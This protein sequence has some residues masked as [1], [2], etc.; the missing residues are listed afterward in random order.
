[1]NNP[2]EQVSAILSEYLVRATDMALNQ[3]LTRIRAQRG[4]FAAHLNRGLRGFAHDVAFVAALGHEGSDPSTGLSFGEYT[5]L[6]EKYRQE[7][8]KLGI[9]NGGMNRF[10]HFS[11][12]LGRDLAT[13]DVTEPG[14]WGKVLVKDIQVTLNDDAQIEHF[15]RRGRQ[16]TGVRGSLGRFT[17]NINLKYF[18]VTVP[19]FKKLQEQWPTKPEYLMFKGDFKANHYALPKLMGY[20]RYSKSTGGA[21]TYRPLVPYYLQW[22]YTVRVP[23]FIRAFQWQA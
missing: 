23:Q 12:D 19:V 2:Q 16:A 14:R 3:S 10:H 13:I 22:Y 20:H 18:Q 21:T 17:K 1:M 9:L 11:G 5:P 15:I 6:N 7:K 4:Q 8:I